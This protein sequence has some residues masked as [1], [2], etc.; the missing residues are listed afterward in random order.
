MSS[1]IEIQKFC[2]YCGKEFTAKTTVT[3]YCGDVCAKRAYKA[4]KRSEKI[5]SAIVEVKPIE[6]LSKKEFLTVREVSK[7]LN[8]SVRS[9][10]YYIES[11]QIQATNLG[12]RLTRVKRSNIDNL[13]SNNDRKQQT[14]VKKQYDISECYTISEAQEKFKISETALQNIIKRETIPKFKKG[15]FV[16][17]PKEL[18]TDIFK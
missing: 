7:L 4:R 5:N 6:D 3:R 17:I 14:P 18:I 10:Y 11:G 16:Y 8:C 1:N 13:F 12:N 9:V 2:E 15:K